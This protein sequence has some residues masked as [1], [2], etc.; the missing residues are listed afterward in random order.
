MFGY[1]VPLRDELKVKD[2]IK[3][4]SYY[5]GL[6]FQL[7]NNL[8]SIPRFLLNY[9]MTFLAILLDS[10]SNTELKFKTKRCIA[11]PFEKK[12]I[13]I[14]NNALKY[15]S[16]IN[17]TLYYHKIKDDVYDNDDIQSKLL[18]KILYQYQKKLDN[19]ISPINNIIKNNLE[20]LT[21]FENNKNFTLIDEICHP[22]SDIVGNILKLYPYELTNDNLILRNNLYALG[23]SL[24]KWIYLID[25][26]D[27]LKD[28]MTFKKFNPLNFLFNKEMKSYDEIIDTIKPKIEFIILNCLYTC[29]DILSKLTIYKNHDILKNILELGMTDKYIGI[30]KKD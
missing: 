19:S 18:E 28:D 10:L 23:Y 1:I 29:K 16:S 5:C 20:E 30:L 14:E 7:K 13:I 15:A 2:F 8:G 25:A 27:D 22:F 3:F 6:C 26:L 9:D 17:L 12:S 24:G 21:N 4:R 11:H